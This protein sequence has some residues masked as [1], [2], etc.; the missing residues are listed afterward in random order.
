VDPERGSDRIQAPRHAH[1]QPVHPCQVVAPPVAQQRRDPGP[2]LPEQRLGVR[3]Q[4]RDLGRGHQPRAGGRV[5]IGVDALLL[6]A[7]GGLGFR[8]VLRAGVALD[9]M[10]EREIRK[11]LG[12]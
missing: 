5:Q 12:G 8:H 3:R 6:G 10:R 2:L 1:E 7:E 4:E 11:V 9:L